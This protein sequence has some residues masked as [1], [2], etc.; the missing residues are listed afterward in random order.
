MQHILEAREHEPCDR[1]MAFSD[2]HFASL[3]QFTARISGICSF[4]WTGFDW[5]DK[6]CDGSTRRV[7]DD[8]EDHQEWCE[9]LRISRWERRDA[10]VREHSAEA[11]HGELV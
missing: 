3:T 1:V 8:R 7:A 9:V 2:P 5:G 11:C 4:S 10:E 6:S